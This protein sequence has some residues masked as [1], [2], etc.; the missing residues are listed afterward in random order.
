MKESIGK[1]KSFSRIV[2][3]E[4]VANYFSEDLDIVRGVVEDKIGVP[5]SLWCGNVSLYKEDVIV[6]DKINDLIIVPSFVKVLKSV[7]TN[8]L[9]ALISSFQEKKVSFSLS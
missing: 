4:V 9:K 2:S 3:S 5:A 8:V 1:T 7:E 6:I